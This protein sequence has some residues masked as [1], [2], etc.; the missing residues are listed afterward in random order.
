MKTKEFIIAL[1]LVS[2]PFVGAYLF[3]EFGSVTTPQ[4][5]QLK[6]EE[7]LSIKE[8]HL[9]KHTYNDLFFLHGKNNP[10]KPVRAIA[11]VPVTITG[12]INLKEIQIIRV[13]DTIRKVIL[14]AA[15][16]TEAC[17]EVDKMM[18]TKTR[19]FQFHAGKDHYPEVSRYLQEVFH[20]R[21]DSVRS[22][23]IRNHIL[24]QAEAEGKEYIEH[25]LVAAGRPDVTVTFNDAVKEKRVATYQQSYQ[26]A[27]R[28]LLHDHHVDTT[29]YHLSFIASE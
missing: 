25:L 14:P 10:E 3:R 19:S 26:F 18:I 1:A 29:V 15:K 8:L 13:N 11:Q 23:A 24:E 28:Q 22:L 5:P 21:K 20:S 4:S 7:V 17:Y 9:V 2:G 6:L 16:I 27:S 12:Y